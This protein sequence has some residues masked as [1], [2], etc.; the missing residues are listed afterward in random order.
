M[1]FL[2][3]LLRLFGLN[4]W[5][6]AIEAKLNADKQ[7]AIEQETEIAEEVENEKQE[8]EDTPDSDV[9]NV[10]DELRDDAVSRRGSDPD[11]NSS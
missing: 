1:N 6:V 3:W 7:E 4:S 11:S 5:A 8:L 2:I 10:L 9:G